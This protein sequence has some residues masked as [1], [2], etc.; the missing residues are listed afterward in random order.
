M[1]NQ[2]YMLFIYLF[3]GIYSTSDLNLLRKM[4]GVKCQPFLNVVT[5]GNEEV[6]IVFSDWYEVII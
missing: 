4:G 3:I 6:A 2:G 1:E 5:T